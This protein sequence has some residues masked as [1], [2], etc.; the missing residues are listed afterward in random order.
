MVVGEGSEGRN[1]FYT[2]KGSVDLPVLSSKVNP[3]P[4]VTPFSLYV[5]SS[6]HKANVT[7]NLL[8]QGEEVHFVSSSSLG[9]L[10][11]VGR[12]Q[13]VVM[14]TRSAEGRTR[15][16]ARPSYFSLY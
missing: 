5:S 3:T 1:E 4:G 15:N 11:V 8:V 2:S 7:E 13:Y 14:S 16:W 10:P 6:T 12:V 9:S